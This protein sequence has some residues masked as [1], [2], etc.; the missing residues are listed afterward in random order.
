MNDLRPVALTSVALITCERIVLPQLTSFIHYSLDPSQFA[1]QS[2]RNC[3]DALLATINEVTSHLDSKLSV[4][5]NKVSGIMT[6]SR[7][8][9]RMMLLLFFLSFQ[10]HSAALA[11]QQ[12]V[13]YVGP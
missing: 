4:E 10:H 13:I 6:K 1:H 9:V 11:G 12:N 2:N 5:K 7:N 8:L 3:E